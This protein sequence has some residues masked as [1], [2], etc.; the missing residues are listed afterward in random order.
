MQCVYSTYFSTELLFCI[1]PPLVVQQSRPL[2]HLVLDRSEIHSLTLVFSFLNLIIPAPQPTATSRQTATAAAGWA[3][4]ARPW[5]KNRRSMPDTRQVR[6]WGYVT[7]LRIRCTHYFQLHFR[8][9]FCQMACSVAKFGILKFH[10]CFKKLGFI[11]CLT[12]R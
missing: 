7:H 1:P 5:W 8:R 2:P 6:T 9:Q 12:S 4:T 10:F 11:Y 3:A